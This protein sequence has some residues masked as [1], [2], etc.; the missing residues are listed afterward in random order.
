VKRVKRSN[1]ARY[2]GVVS[3]CVVLETSLSVMRRYLRLRYAHKPVKPL[4]MR[5]VMVRSTK[6]VL[7]PVR[8][9]KSSTVVMPVVLELEYVSQE[10]SRG[11]TLLRSS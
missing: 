6:G 10:L 1:A 4:E 9:V 8:T 7:V 5:T 3:A 11:V 2:V